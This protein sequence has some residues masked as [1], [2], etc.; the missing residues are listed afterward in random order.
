MKIDDEWFKN[1]RF[2]FEELPVGIRYS[3]EITT[4]KPGFSLIFYK[5]DKRWAEM[6]NKKTWLCSVAIGGLEISADYGE[7]ANEAF[8]KIYSKIQ[9]YFKGLTSSLT[10]FMKEEK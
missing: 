9:E 6:A 5:Y 10:E 8:E 2:L 4:I 3:K 1:N 7:T